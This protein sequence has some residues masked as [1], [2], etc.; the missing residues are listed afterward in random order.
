MLTF[1]VFPQVNIGPQ[2]FPE[3]SVKGKIGREKEWERE[4]KGRSG[5]GREEL[6]GKGR[7]G[8]KGK[9]REGKIG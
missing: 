9:R 4:R 6:G 2:T 5:K 3:D 8:G 1:P 7:G